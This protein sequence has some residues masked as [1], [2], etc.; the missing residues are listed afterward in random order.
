MNEKERE[1]ETENDRGG[2]DAS[3]RNGM[4]LNAESWRWCAGP[5]C[6]VV[7]DSGPG[8][9]SQPGR[10]GQAGL[11]GLGGSSPESSPKSATGVRTPPLVRPAPQS[12]GPPTRPPTMASLSPRRAGAPLRYAGA[13]AFLLMLII[14][15]IASIVHG[16]HRFAL[17]TTFL[18][19]RV[20]VETFFFLDTKL[21]TTTPPPLRAR[22]HRYREPAAKECT[23]NGP[24]LTSSGIRNSWRGWV[25]VLAS[26]NAM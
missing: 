26:W 9:I 18:V 10:P 12:A 23:V 2:G 24:D 15:I 6:K 16:M 5:G 17:A 3:K 8:D 4:G 20:S 13:R 7:Q 11:P 1:K 22:T 14:I 25:H 19:E 21:P